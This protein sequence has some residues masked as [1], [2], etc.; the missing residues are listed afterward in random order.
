MEDS[1]F[2][3]ESENENEEIRDEYDRLYEL[4]YNNQIYYGVSGYITLR[5]YCANSFKYLPDSPIRGTC[6]SLDD[7]DKSKGYN[8]E[9]Y[10]LDCN[11]DYLVRFCFYSYNILSHSVLYN[12]AIITSDLGFEINRYFRQVEKVIENIGYMRKVQNNL[13]KF[14]PKDEV[15]ISVAEIVD[16]NL[17]HRVIEYNHISMKGNLQGKKD[18]LRDLA[19]KLEP[20]RDKL[21]EG[22]SK[23]AKDLFFLL[24]N[25]NVRHNNIDQ[26]GSSYIPYVANMKKEELEQW[27]DNIYQ[28]CLLAFLEL[29]HLDRKDSIKQLKQN[30]NPNN[31]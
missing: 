1:H 21:T 22:N 7:Y 3:P 31:S 5:G 26:S 2:L 13:M 17:S 19:D 15:V 10:P 12:R 27:Y 23:L 24:N 16:Q 20:K 30:I 25:V 8:F 11:R 6:I 14:I 28:M 18:I 29:E 4:F 9:E